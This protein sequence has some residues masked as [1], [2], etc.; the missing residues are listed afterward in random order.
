VIKSGR[1]EE[2][3]EGEKTAKLQQPAEQAVQHNTAHYNVLFTVN[4][5]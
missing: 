3:E 4:Y 5:S 1:E 2:E